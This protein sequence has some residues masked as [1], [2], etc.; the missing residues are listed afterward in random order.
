[1]NEQKTG[2]FFSFEAEAQLELLP[3]VA[4][5]EQLLFIYFFITSPSSFISDLGHRQQLKRSQSP[6][7]DSISA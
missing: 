5:T 4:S 7:T 2:L 3:S 6:G 1:M